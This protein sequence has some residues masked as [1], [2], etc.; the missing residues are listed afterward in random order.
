MAVTW[1]PGKGDLGY[2]NG[3]GCPHDHH[4]E[5][6]RDEREEGDET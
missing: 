6:E 1:L 2:C 5:E 3:M 4:H